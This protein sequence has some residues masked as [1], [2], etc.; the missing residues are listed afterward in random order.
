MLQRYLRDH[1]PGNVVERLHSR[2]PLP[3]DAATVVL[4]NDDEM[5]VEL[6]REMDAITDEEIL[7]NVAKARNGMLWESTLRWHHC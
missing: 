5:I 7:L 4:Q 3:V 6:E 1:N 2:P